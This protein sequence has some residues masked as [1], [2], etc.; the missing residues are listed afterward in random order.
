MASR[1]TVRITCDHV[2][3]S[4]NRKC[5]YDELLENIPPT[6]PV[7][8]ITIKIEMV[9]REGRTTLVDKQMDVCVY[10]V[11]W[12][13]RQLHSDWDAEIASRRQGADEQASDD[14]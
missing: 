6:Q 12:T 11:Y 5:T 9:D 7:A 10:D 1:N 2:H 14:E 8:H 4:N 13:L 3:S